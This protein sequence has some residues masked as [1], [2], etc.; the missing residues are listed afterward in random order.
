MLLTGNFALRGRRSPKSSIRVSDVAC[1]CLESVLRWI[2]SGFMDVHAVLPMAICWVFLGSGAVSGEQ[3]MSALTTSD[4][5]QNLSAEDADRHYP[6]EL[7]GVITYIDAANDRAYLQDETGGV[8]FRPGGGAPG[9]MDPLTPGDRI[10]ITGVSL[11]G[12]GIAQVAG[13]PM[14]ADGSFPAVTFQRAGHGTLPAPMPVIVEQV[15]NGS[16]QSQYVTFRATIR[17]NSVEKVAGGARITLYFSGP[18]GFDGW[19]MSATL[20]TRGVP[21]TTGWDNQVAMVSGV[22]IGTGENSK[23]PK[24]PQLLIPT[25]NQVSF[26]DGLIRRTFEQIPRELSDIF[27]HQKIRPGGDTPFI[28][29]Q[30]S[31]TLSRP[32]EGIYVGDGVHG[33]WVQTPQMTATR[34]GDQVDVVGLPGQDQRGA[35][36]KDAIFRVTG[37]Q[38]LL[39]A[40]RVNPAQAVNAEH[41]AARMALEGEL[42][43]DIREDGFRW[44]LLDN[45]G[46]R[47]HARI[48]SSHPRDSATTW[49]LGSWLRVTGVGEAP[50][51][52]EDGGP[53]GFLTLLVD[54]A[55]DVAVVRSAPW[56]T[57]ERV[58]LLIGALLTSIV[59][60]I[61]WAALLHR[62][63]ARQTYIIT[64]KT[65]QTTL[66]EERQRM[67]RELHDTLEQHL[68]GIQVRI[69]SANYWLPDA[70]ANV[71]EALLEARGMLDHS[72]AEARRSIFELRS[73]ALDEFSL[74]DAVRS[75]ARQVG[76][77]GTLHVEV[78]TTGTEIRLA[79]ATEFHILRIIQEAI[80]NALK[81]AEAKGI[82]I[83]FDY[84]RS[85]LR[86]T[87]RDDGK[88]FDLAQRA[89]DAPYHFGLMG[90]RERV[91][92][93]KGRLDL[94]S[95]PDAGT[96]LVIEIPT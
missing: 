65:K 15:Q 42:V 55:K 90:I 22:A 60:A 10:E 24:R 94:T 43:G 21:D 87:I 84:T 14:A 11:A 3:P 96:M 37:H 29:V 17:S 7:K 53:P 26:D 5:V 31:V 58:R 40:P 72:R 75:S 4:E 71:K 89:V 49:K 85:L 33:L 25:V 93:I 32:G 74:P 28:R 38:P 34:L 67:A 51:S 12:D 77:N 57:P 35:Y 59:L 95:S 83:V 68:V 78:N 88:G 76:E 27:H 91:V 9:N 50:P 64:E 20:V 2:A 48:L 16:V 92:R 45:G 30:G 44:V 18:R 80:T 70:P 52:L 13:G 47:I 19:R 23:N 82:K 61:L 69:D 39:Q 63:V 6:V 8:R 73:S 41:H 62:Q 54:S 81:H 1:E 46:R 36:L 66:D 86:V 79:R 56:F